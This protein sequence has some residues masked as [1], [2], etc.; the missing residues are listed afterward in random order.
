MKT[1]IKDNPFIKFT[2]AFIA[3]VESDKE[4][5]IDLNKLKT[6]VKKYDLWKQKK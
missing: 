3:G 4:N 1:I 6:A 5:R 2:K